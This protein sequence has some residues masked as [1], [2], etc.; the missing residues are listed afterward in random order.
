[1]SRLPCSPGIIAIRLPRGEK[2]E[3]DLKPKKRNRKSA[4]SVF[5]AQIEEWLEQGL[6]VIRMLELSRANAEHPYTGSE[7]AFY[8]YVRNMQEET[9]LRLLIECFQTIGD[10]PWV[11]VID[12]MKTAVL[13]RN[14]SNQPIWNPAYQKLAAEFKFLPEACAPASGTRKAQ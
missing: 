8:D 2:V 14:A 13:G 1:M 9:V 11:V 5:D 10:V 12:N 7:T 6:P 4:A 3:I